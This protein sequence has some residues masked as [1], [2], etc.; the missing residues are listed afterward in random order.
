MHW[1]L[2]DDPG[3][4]Y[5]HQVF[6]QV[7]ISNNAWPFDASGKVTMNTPE[8]VAALK[9]YTDLKRCARPARNT[10]AAR[11]KCTNLINP[12]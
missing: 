9:F 7:A 8:M 3:Q 4:N 11:V 5:P 12:A 1:S 10:G 6:E 2:P